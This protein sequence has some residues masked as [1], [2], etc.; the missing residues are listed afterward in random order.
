MSR[1][2]SLYGNL[3]KDPLSVIVRAIYLG[4]KS[5]VLY[6]SSKNVSKRIYFN[7]GSIVFAG[8][9][10]DEDRLGEVLV[11]EG[12]IKRSD[13]EFAWQIMKKTGQSLVETIIEMEFMSPQEIEAQSARRM[14]HIVYSSFGWVSGKYRF[15]ELENPVAED[16]AMNLSP[17]DVILEGTR[18]IQDPET[19]KSLLGDLKRVISKPDVAALPLEEN[20]L[21][22]QERVV[23]DLAQSRADG[24]STVFDLAGISPLDADETLRC[25]CSLVSV[26]ALA[27][28]NPATAEPAKEAADG[29]E[30]AVVT[31]T[32][33]HLPQRL[34]RYEVQELLGRGSMGAVFLARDPAIERVVAIKLIQAATFLT[35]REQE[36]YR[37]R[38]RREAKA[39]GKL[40]HPGIVTVFD[41]GHADQESPFI[42]MEYAEGPTLAALTQE[43][44]LEVEET[45]QVAHE[46]L[47]ALSYAHSFGIVHRDIKPANILVTPG[48]HPKIMDFG[49]AHVVGTQLTPT[50]H[51]LGSPNYMAPEQLSKGTIDQRT[52]LF[53]F[54]VVIYRL[55]TRKL[56]FT[57]DSFAAAAQAILTEKPASPESINPN[58]SPALG[59]IVLR[60][61]AKD[62][63]DRFAS[64]EEV[65]KAL[66]SHALGLPMS[67]LARTGA[68]AETA[69]T[70]TRG[71]AG[72]VHT[73]MD[74]YDATAMDDSGGTRPL[75]SAV[76]P[77]E[78]KA[79][80]STP[81]RLLYAAITVPVIAAAVVSF[82]VLPRSSMR[83][84][85]P[86]PQ[87][88]DSASQIE[89]HD[90]VQKGELQAPTSYEQ[91]DD[92]ELFFAANEDLES[93]AAADAQA[94]LEELLRR[95][96]EFAGAADLLAKAERDP[97]RGVETVE[98]VH[99]EDVEISDET[100]PPVFRTEAQ[101]YRE[102][103][104]ALERGDN[105][106]GRVKLEEL[107]D[108]NPNFAGAPELLARARGETKAPPRT[109]REAAA[110]SEPQL[111]YEATLA[112]ESGDFETSKARLEEALRRNPTFS[113]AS[114]LLTEVDDEIWKK[115]LPVSFEARHRHRFGS[116]IGSLS[117]EGGSIGFNSDAHEWKWE[118]SAIRV[119]ERT[120]AK[121]VIIETYEADVLGMGKPKR[122]K[123]SLDQPL[124]RETW[125][126]YERIA[127]R[128]TLSEESSE[129]ENDGPGQ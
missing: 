112:R 43:R 64:A 104:Q 70:P 32:S 36:R 57:G 121:N 41:V 69:Q 11:R 21:S 84:E 106:T 107:L 58:V 23:L 48:L 93:G 59:G 50:E 9:D 38:F 76:P 99:G 80:N 49:I 98:M 45:V 111:F 51:S 74:L 28:E 82:L 89:L 67:N 83:G 94:K 10:D 34:G 19:I 14:K 65:K 81:R 53:A 54:G 92:S 3:G 40:I 2:L 7:K 16:V 5:G 128:E 114:E 26:G 119:M 101:L 24:S 42:V 109:G 86:P 126:R 47:D 31:A 77:V 12:K 123:F 13:L 129:P 90:A 108:R 37:N 17:V 20:A 4:G 62:P 61:L 91:L 63:A 100:S 115:T 39:A 118:L 71:P 22:A 113:G 29:S 88:S 102:A 46:I 27:I 85:E 52:D 87:I 18:G 96:P 95:D 125:S 25:L 1:I 127:R 66:A 15:E 79:P 60:C 73:D 117:L 120:D 97:E 78:P 35:A 122:Y 8:S 56:P 105:E 6:L 30:S 124:D 44:E 103:K 68:A 33:T 116:C 75:E 72:G 55:L 110:L